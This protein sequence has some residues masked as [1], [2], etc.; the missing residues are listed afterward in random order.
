MEL[1]K[2]WLKLIGQYSINPS[3]QKKLWSEIE[4]AYQQPE[5]FYHNLEHLIYLVELGIQYQ[6]HIEDFN[7]LLFAIFYHDIIYQIKEKDNEIKSAELAVEKLS[8]IKYPQT[9]IRK[10]YYQIIATKKHELNQDKDTNL[11]LDFDLAILGEKRNKYLEYAENIR[12]E[13]LIYPDH[14][15]NQGRRQVLQEFLERNFLYKT[16]LFQ[17]KFEETARKNL[18]WE[19]GQLRTN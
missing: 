7:T 16:K 3:L 1:K 5:R 18:N 19:L 12:K 11:L 4:T 9:Q 14:I 2:T 10:C 17:D 15:Y 6:S 8:L 13:Y